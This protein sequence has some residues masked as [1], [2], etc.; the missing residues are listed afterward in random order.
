M[1]IK[2]Q[3]V[4][5]LLSTDIPRYWELIK[6]T[7]AK[8]NEVHERT[9]QAFFNELLHALLNNKAQCF[10]RIGD[11]NKIT[12][13][14]VTRIL[15]D[16]ITGGKYILI[17]SLYSFRPQRGDVRMEELTFMQEFAEAEG[18]ERCVYESNNP[19]VWK[20]GEMYGAKEDYRVFSYHFTE[21]K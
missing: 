5:R 4:I 10:V 8:T 13:V 21:K 3:K 17:Q 9:F 1:T 12:T 2:G 14:Y 11:D 15:E 7:V 18:C 20:I 6:F 19:R 16:K